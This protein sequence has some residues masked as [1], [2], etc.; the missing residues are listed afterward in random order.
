MLQVH[1][2]L[3]V[4]AIL[5]V[6]GA[7]IHAQEDPE[8]DV[9]ARIQALETEIASLRQAT[10]Q[11]TDVPIFHPTEVCEPCVSSA[12]APSRFPAVKVTGFFQA[13][14]GWV[15]Q[16][17]ANQI[18]LGDIQDGADFRRARLAATGD[19]ADNVGYMVEFDFG[20][21]G[22]P[23]FMD[24]W[25]EVRDT[26][27]LNNVKIGQFRHP[28]GLD[29]LTSVKEL[30]FIER[31]LPFAFLPFRQIG[32]MSSGANEDLGTTWAV[33]GFRFPTDP[34]GGQIGDDGGYGMASR[35]TAVLLEGSDDAVLHIGG[36]YSLIDP[37]NDAVRYRTQPEFFIA[38]TGGAAF[39]P[40]GVPSQVPVFVDTGDIPTNTANLF[41]AELAGTRGPLHAQTEV[42]HALVDRMGASNVSFSGVSAQTGYVLTGEHRPYN[43][44]AGVLG[45]IVPYNDF[46]PCG[47]G[48]WEIAARWSMLDL[49]DADIRGGR[50]NTTTL[51]LNWYLNQ[52]SKFQFNYIHA[53]LDSAAGV[54][55]DADFFAVRA[56]VDF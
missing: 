39:V 15:H 11:S 34:F 8:T 23:S 9:V 18:A 30:T 43:H 16:D 42:I 37:A 25:L 41:A 51:G 47:G 21:P 24:V 55:S 29:G 14:A 49:N 33:S 10:A 26:A 3:L 13:D 4:L 53:F 38:E 35:L 32:L 54:D 12:A 52:Y 22:R 7:R 6:T 56:Q 2:I 31:G 46:G 28:L 19:V 17:V 50:L 45:R 5:L 27:L 20:F 1:P 44:K 48:A 40:T 36:A